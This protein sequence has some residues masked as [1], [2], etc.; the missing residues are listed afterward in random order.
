MNE[1]IICNFTNPPQLSPSLEGFIGC[2]SKDVQSPSFTNP[3]QLS[4]SLE[5]FIGC[6]SKDVQ[7]PGFTN[8]PQL[9]PSLEGLL[10]SL[11][12][13]PLRTSCSCSF[14]NMGHCA[15]ENNTHVFTFTHV[16][17]SLSCFHFHLEH[18]RSLEH[19]GNL[20][21]SRSLEHSRTF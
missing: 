18:S 17:N 5:G 14:L 8:P 11:A 10:S 7:R 12:T 2:T 4:P 6:T 20:E 13:F 9:S 16:T 3:P 19:S 21:H 1:W 15:T